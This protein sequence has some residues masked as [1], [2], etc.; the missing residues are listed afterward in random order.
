VLTAVTTITASGLGRARPRERAAVQASPEPTRELHAHR[1]RG[2]HGHASLRP[3]TG[4]LTEGTCPDRAV[5]RPRLV[6]AST[7]QPSVV[8]DVTSIARHAGH[9]DADRVAPRQLAITTVLTGTTETAAAVRGASQ[10]TIATAVAVTDSAA[11]GDGVRSFHAEH[12]PTDGGG[13]RR[14]QRTGGQHGAPPTRRCWPSRRQVI[15][16]TTPPKVA[17]VRRGHA[18]PRRPRVQMGQQAHPV[19]GRGQCASPA[20]DLGS[21]LAVV[22]APM[23]TGPP[24]ENLTSVE[25]HRPSTAVSRRRVA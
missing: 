6:H 3:T 14:R 9:R 5:S 21:G 15:D 19:G 11:L 13:A 25:S 24:T 1:R 17:D 18:R 2:A 10:L 16:G 22:I 7:E 20:A 23:S 8:T 12:P 4:T